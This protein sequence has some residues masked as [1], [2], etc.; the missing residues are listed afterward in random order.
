MAKYILPIEFVVEAPNEADA[1]AHGREIA[2][3]LYQQHAVDY[4]LMGQPRPTEAPDTPPRA[5]AAPAPAPQ[6]AAAGRRR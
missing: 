3:L 4:Y 1:L 2:A 5:Q 6:P